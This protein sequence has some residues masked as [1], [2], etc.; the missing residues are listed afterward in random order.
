LTIPFAGFL[1]YIRASDILA[2]AH[3]DG[4]SGLMVVL[5]IHT[6]QTADKVVGEAPAPA[7]ER[8]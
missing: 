3:N 1:L 2:E 7:S 5:T 8:I 6:G 4:S